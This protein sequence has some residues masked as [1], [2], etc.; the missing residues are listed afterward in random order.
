MARFVVKPIVDFLAVRN[1]L[2]FAAEIVFAMGIILLVLF[3]AGLFSKTAAAK[4]TIYKIE[5]KLLSRLPMYA[6]IK[7]ISDNVLKFECNDS[8][9]TVLIEA[10]SG[11]RIAFLVEKLS[12]G[13][14]VVY[15]PD[16]PNPW[17][18]AL[19]FIDG[20]KLEEVDISVKDAMKILTSLGEKSEQTLKSL[21]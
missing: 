2:G 5:D 20:E 10:D 9:K 17:D 19:I 8:W 4:N 7:H 14:S 13:N 18:G 1:I 15:L 12:N 16:A 11:K 21:L 6:Q 3:L